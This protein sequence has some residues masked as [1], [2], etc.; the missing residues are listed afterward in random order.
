MPTNYERILAPIMLALCKFL[1][2]PIMLKIMQ[3]YSTHESCQLLL[4]GSISRIN[5][6]RQLYKVLYIKVVVIPLITILQPA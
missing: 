4:L 3:A 6:V 5:K 1:K 2:M